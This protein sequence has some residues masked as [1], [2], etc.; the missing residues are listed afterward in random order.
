M[1]LSGVRLDDVGLLGP[2]DCTRDCGRWRSVLDEGPRRQ[3]N[4]RVRYHVVLLI[5]A[6]RNGSRLER[7]AAAWCVFFS[8]FFFQ[9][10]VVIHVYK[11]VGNT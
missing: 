9:F 4:V 3:C 6:R 11:D 5:C 7:L 10:M 8:S 1:L 2:C